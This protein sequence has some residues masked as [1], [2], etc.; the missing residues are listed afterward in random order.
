[1]NEDFFVF[2]LFALDDNPS[3]I[4][5]D[6]FDD[7]DVS[8]VF[9]SINDR[10]GSHVI[11]TE[12]NSKN[13]ENGIFSI[14]VVSLFFFFSFSILFLY[15]NH[16][17]FYL[18][19]FFYYK[20]YNGIN[21]VPGEYN[22][23]VYINGSEINKYIY[24]HDIDECADY[25]GNNFLSNISVSVTR[26]EFSFE[27]STVLFPG[28]NVEHKTNSLN[29]NKL[30]NNNYGIKTS[31]NEEFVISVI[32]MDR[33]GN[34][35]CCDGLFDN[36]S[37]IKNSGEEQASPNNIPTESLFFSFSSRINCSYVKNCS[38]TINP[39]D[40]G[41]SHPTLIYL[42]QSF[43]VC[44]YAHFFTIT[45]ALGSSE[46]SS[47]LYNSSLDVKVISSSPVSS[48]CEVALPKISFH[49]FIYLFIYFHEKFFHL[50]T[51]P[52]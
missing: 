27:K 33:Y 9:T 45:P 38:Y 21:F 12:I 35:G 44:D 22:A 40:M 29:N 11:E 26:G 1:L 5:C 4:L 10:N 31:V 51:L 34:N 50:L 23:K 48:L 28:N 32:C 8:L 49:L 46:L 47:I 24:S 30:N 3:P 41:I 7:F 16:I 20:S 36:N 15:L 19:I 18:F 17:F 25:D 42:T 2:T 37:T 52:M 13:C 43:F 14:A 39:I 6:L